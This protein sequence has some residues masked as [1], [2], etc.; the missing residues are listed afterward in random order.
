[1]TSW[2]AL[3]AILQV[4][5]HAL[6][7][8]VRHEGLELSGYM[9]FMALLGFFPFLIFVTAIAG[10]IG[11]AE[12]AGSFIRLALG[13]LPPEVGAV[14]GPVVAGIVA[15]P[16]GDLLTFSILFSVWSA[17][18]GVEALRLLLNRCYA[19]AETRSV[20]LLRLQ[21][22]AIV[23]LGALAV[24][25]ISLLIVLAPMLQRL[26]AYLHL[27]EAVTPGTWFRLRY[28]V[29][30]PSTM[31]VLVALHVF[32]P[33]RRLRLRDIWPGT[34]ITT[35]LWLGGAAGFS[36][37]VENLGTYDV[38][39]GS[40]GGI[41]LSLLFFYVSA[42]IFGFGAEMNAAIMRWRERL[43]AREVGD[44]RHAVDPGSGNYRAVDVVQVESGAG[45]RD[46]PR[47][48]RKSGRE[49]R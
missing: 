19:V 11:Q 5:W 23:I 29:A 41:V 28:G 3:R 9:S 47:S 22:V 35:A 33:N 21:S 15:K 27:S 24:V 32:L 44:V 16:R 39:Y 18:S 30:L 1:M 36:L 25:A 46:G 10:F 26:L 8:L 49:R 38:T 42:V 20:Y 2:T 31:A 12:G 45:R 48:K 34:L 40:L 4:L 6:A 14:L 7:N 17:S 43:P 13:L 37:Y